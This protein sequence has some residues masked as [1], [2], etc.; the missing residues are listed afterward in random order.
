MRNLT[1]RMIN[2]QTYAAAPFQ[3]EKLLTD[4]DANGDR[5]L[6][7]T[8]TENAKEILKQKVYESF[9]QMPQRF[10]QDRHCKSAALPFCFVTFQS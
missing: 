2:C 10:Q 3:T 1:L 5:A 9:S 7:E 8:E 6:D 4:Y